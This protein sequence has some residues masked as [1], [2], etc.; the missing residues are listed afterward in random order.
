MLIFIIYALHSADNECYDCSRRVRTRATNFILFILFLFIG[1]KTSQPIAHQYMII[2]CGCKRTKMRRE[3]E[4]KDGTFVVRFT[5]QNESKR[6]NGAI[7]H[8]NP[9]SM[10]HFCF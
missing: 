10:S 1:Q 9:N 3:R 4:R 5:E 2:K 7:R 6:L 8:C